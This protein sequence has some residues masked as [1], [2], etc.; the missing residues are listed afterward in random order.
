MYYIVPR[1]INIWF[2]F[3]SLK[4][5]IS[6]LIIKKILHIFFSVL[7]IKRSRIVK[8]ILMRGIVSNNIQDFL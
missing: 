1:T 3:G 2:K 8:L 7:K 4:K 5:S 6:N